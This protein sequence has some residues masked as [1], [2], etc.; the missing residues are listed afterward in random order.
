MQTEC[1]G[2]AGISIGLW[3]YLRVAWLSAARHSSPGSVAAAIAWSVVA[4]VAL[5]GVLTWGAVA[6]QDSLPR[7]VISES[8]FCDSTTFVMAPVLL[9]TVL[10]LVM[11]SARRS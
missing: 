10:A 5:V 11:L 2:R 9:I 1:S 6:W 7:L 3:S 4:V 8:S